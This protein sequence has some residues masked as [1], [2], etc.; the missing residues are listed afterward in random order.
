MSRFAKHWTDEIAEISTREEFQNALIEIWGASEEAVYDI[1]TGEWTYPTNPEPIYVGR[2][3]IIDVRWGVSYG[4]ESQGNAKTV[5]SIR[6]Q[7]P[8]NSVGK[9]LKGAGVTVISSQDNPSLGGTRFKIT[10][11]LQGTA[12]AARTFEAAVD[13]DAEPDE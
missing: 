8:K 10:S 2:A 3:R 7:V 12:Q 1:D 5:T 4:G 6:V 9:I 11:G 13:G